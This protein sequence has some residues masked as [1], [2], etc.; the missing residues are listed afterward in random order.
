MEFELW[1]LV[2]LL[3][4]FFGCVGTFGKVLLAQF[5]ARLDERFNGLEDGHTKALEVERQL[6]IFKAELP[7][8][9]V[10]REDYVRNQTV[11][12]AKL[13]AVASKIENLQ[14]KTKG[15]S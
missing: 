14:L 10:R 1:H 4:A 11:I 5:E 9:Y 2:L 12:E 7:L 6:L 3:M 15:V 8:Q 13:D